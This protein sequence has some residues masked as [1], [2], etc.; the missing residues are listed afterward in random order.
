MKN[1]YKRPDHRQAFDLAVQLIE[2]GQTD[3]RKIA[4]Q[5]D[6]SITREQRLKIAAKTCNRHG[7]KPPKRVH[8]ED[9]ASPRTD[10]E[11]I[12]L[13]MWIQATP[14]QRLVLLCEMRRFGKILS[15]QFEFIESE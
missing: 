7:I 12:A 4:K 14:E 11:A 2:S 8:I 3:Y 9:I 5:L 6:H 10:E 15:G 13:A 1:P